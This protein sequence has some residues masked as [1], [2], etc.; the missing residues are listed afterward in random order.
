MLRT[1]RLMHQEL[2]NKADYLK[3]KN[4]YFLAIKRAKREH[5]NQFLIKED[6]QSI[7]KAMSYTKDSQ[8]SRIPTILGESDFKGKCKALKN[9]LFPTPPEATRPNWSKY[10]PSSWKWPS[11][12]VVKLA[13]A[14]SA[15]VK[16]KTPGLDG[17]TQEIILYAY[18]AIPEVFLSLFSSLLDLGY[19]PIY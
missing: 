4:T 10:R 5:W 9:T 18:Q 16:G 1:Q 11:L 15:K 2:G 8:V 19:Y 13:D 6:S 17:I 12:T 3:A 14:C 7:Y